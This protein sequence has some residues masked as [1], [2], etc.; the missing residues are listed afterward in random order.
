MAPKKTAPREMAIRW[1]GAS[2]ATRRTSPGSF[3]EPPW[4]PSSTERKAREV[5]ALSSR[6]ERMPVK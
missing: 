5:G 1:A 6:E 2:V 4:S 3:R